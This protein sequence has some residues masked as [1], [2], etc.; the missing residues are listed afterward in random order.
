MNT[1][2][3]AVELKAKASVLHFAEVAACVGGCR[4]S[5]V[6]SETSLHKLAIPLGHAPI[7]GMGLVLNGGIGVAG[8]VFGPASDHILEL[9]VVTAEGDV[10]SFLTFSR[11]SLTALA[12][13][14]ASCTMNA[15]GFTMQNA[16]GT[17]IA[18]RLSTKQQYIAEHVQELIGTMLSLLCAGHCKPNFP[19]RAIL[20]YVRSWICIWRGHKVGSEIK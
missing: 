9:T 5:D 6:D 10:V 12:G 4:L 17:S 11:A 14:Q 1:S 7:T 3:S 18:A 20:G 2:I 13:S 16:L 19:Y 15:P 8:K